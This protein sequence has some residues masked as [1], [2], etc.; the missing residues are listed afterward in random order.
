M[1]E[2]SLH[3]LDI[4]QNSI[5]AQASLVEIIILEYTD[6]NALSIEIIDNGKGMDKETIQKVSDPF[7]TSRTTRKVGLGI[8][9]F[10][11]A[12]EQCNGMFLISS[13]IDKGTKVLAEFERD[14]IDRAPL[15]DIAE[16]ISLLIMTN[17]HI[18][19]IYTYCFNEQVYELDTREIKKV[20][21]DMPISNL[22]VIDWIKENIN[23]G[24][25]EIQ[26]K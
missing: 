19:F 7:W 22:E 6:K 1:K 2:L 10:K 15:G 18:D 25:K 13:E 20:L 12:A 23:E 5:A 11:A 4:V 24:I 21:G 16:T 14:H 3:I 26:I 17:E 9:L 8:P